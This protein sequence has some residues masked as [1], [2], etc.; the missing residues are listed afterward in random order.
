MKPL[1]DGR[2]RACGVIEG[3]NPM[4]ITTGGNN[5]SNNSLGSYTQEANRVFLAKASYC[6]AEQKLA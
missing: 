4:G 3:G 1:V 2:Y 5:S 6:Q